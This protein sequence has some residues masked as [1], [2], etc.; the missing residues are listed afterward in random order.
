MKNWIVRNFFQGHLDK[1]REDAAREGSIDAFEKAHADIM[2]TMQNDLEE[3]ANEL[4]EQKVAQL[5]SVVDPRM[6]VTFNERQG[7]IFIGGERATEHQLA[8]FKSEAE[9]ITQMDIWRIITESPKE[10]AMRAMFVAGESIDDLK[11]GRAML[12]T[13]ATQQRILDTFKSFVPKKVINNT[14]PT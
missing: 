7:A 6:V 12:Y 11:K 1:M 10:L 13:L 5:L 2:A 8:N 4:A 9:A 3:R 14:P